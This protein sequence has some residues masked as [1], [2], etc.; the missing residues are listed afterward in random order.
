MQ[1]FQNLS[2]GW[3][4]SIRLETSNDTD[5]EEG[6]QAIARELQAISLTCIC[7]KVMEHI[8]VSNVINHFQKHHILNGFQHGFRKLH[9]CETQLI[10]FI[11]DIAREMQGG[12]QTDIIVMDFSK[13]FDKVPHKEL[14]FKLSNYGIDHYTLGWIQ[15]FLKNRQQ[16]TILER[17]RSS[18]THVTSEVPQGS[19]L[20]PILFLAFINDL[21]KCIK[22]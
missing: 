15:N 19:A 16:C 9:S 10:G 13:A 22:C 8:L 6:I 12:E 11:N 1:D 17:E 2:P 14:I 5:F 18:Y 4:S 20:G 3:C 21:P 7:S